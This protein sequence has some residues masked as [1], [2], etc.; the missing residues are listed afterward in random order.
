MN[1]RPLASHISGAF[2]FNSV[3]FPDPASEGTIRTKAA[4]SEA[5]DDAGDR[6]PAA[7]LGTENVQPTPVSW[8]S[9][10]AT[11]H[12]PDIYFT[13]LASPVKTSAKQ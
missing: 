6:I 12:R 5:R 8:Q 3:P 2:D 4:A 1:C 13:D 7:S 9:V 11:K 10:N